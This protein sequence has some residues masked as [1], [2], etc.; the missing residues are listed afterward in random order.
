MSRFSAPLPPS[1]PLLQQ[2][3]DYFSE[4]KL[5][6]SN[7][8]PFLRI[9]IHFWNWILALQRNLQPLHFGWMNV[10]VDTLE[11]ALKA[12][13]VL[14]R[15]QFLAKRTKNKY[16]RDKKAEDIVMDEMYIYI[17]SWIHWGKKK[18]VYAHRILI[19]TVLGKCFSSSITLEW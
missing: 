2:P 19:S 13:K 8:K 9:W 5:E 7:F 6:K 4:N 17:Y 3:L 1:Q 10:Q 15:I 14:L 18:H 16:N 12:P 11:T